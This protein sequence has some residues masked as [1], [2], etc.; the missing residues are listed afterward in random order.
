MTRVYLNGMDISDRVI[1]TSIEESLTADAQIRISPVEITVSNLD[2]AYFRAGK[3]HLPPGIALSLIEVRIEMDT[4]TWTGVLSGIDTHQ[5]G[6]AVLTAESRLAQIMSAPVTASIMYATPAQAIAI[7]AASAGLRTGTGL[8]IANAEQDGIMVN[9]LLT[10]ADNISLSQ[11]ISSIAELASM[12][13]I[14]S[15]NALDAAVPHSVDPFWRI[16]SPEAVAIQGY[17]KIREIDGY[18]VAYIGSGGV[19]KSGGA[20]KGN[21]WTQECGPASWLQVC[22]GGSASAL[23]EKAM[24]RP[25]WSLVAIT[26]KDAVYATPGSVMQIDIPE[27]GMNETAV[28]VGVVP[29][30]DWQKITLEERR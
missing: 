23:G 19:P 13:L 17:S 16:G 26:R 15:D 7:L 3:S 27:I 9:V 5:L 29:E 10:E 21:I 25:R 8:A 24:L 22:D 18:S 6:L 12:R 28:V 1:S 30:D 2:S 20:A 14:V 4:G 11:A